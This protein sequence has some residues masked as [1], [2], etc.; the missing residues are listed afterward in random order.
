MTLPPPPE[1][2]PHAAVWI[3]FPS[4]PE[5][6]A[7]D[8]APA[9]DEVVAFARAVWA[10]GKGEEVLLVAADAEAAEA[11]GAMAPFAT[12]VVE[13]FGD[14]WLRD[15]GPIVGGDGVW[16][17]TSGAA[18][19]CSTGWPRWSRSACGSVVRTPCGSR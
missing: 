17:G 10:G 3:G 15:T 12:V 8:L 4:H 18:A 11:A 14:I 7:D 2:A 5:L 9:R 6:W 1:W 19:E 13:P 16:V